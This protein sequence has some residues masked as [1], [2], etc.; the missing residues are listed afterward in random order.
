MEKTEGNEVQR[1][2]A[3]RRAALVV[4]LFR[5]ETSL[6]EAARAHGLTLGELED[7]RDK[8]LQGAENALREYSGP[9]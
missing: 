1:W 8:F 6:A 5:G 4:S 9:G 2:T 7:W 3:K